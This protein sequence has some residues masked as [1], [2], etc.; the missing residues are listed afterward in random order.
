MG[1]HPGRL[2]ENHPRRL[3]S[4]LTQPQLA[5]TLGKPR[6]DTQARQPLTAT[7]TDEMTTGS[8]GFSSSSVSTTPILSTTS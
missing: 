5:G 2:E 8:T 7:L 1:A 3:L 6:Y 4:L